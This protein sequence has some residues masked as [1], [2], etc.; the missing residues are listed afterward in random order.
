MGTPKKKISKK[1]FLLQITFLFKSSHNVP[2]Q[3]PHFKGY[4][5]CKANLRNK[6]QGWFAKGICRLLSTMI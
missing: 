1:K 4:D 5:A 2:Q 3:T 6:R